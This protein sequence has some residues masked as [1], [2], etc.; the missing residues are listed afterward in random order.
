MPIDPDVELVLTDINRRLDENVVIVAGIRLDTDTARDIANSAVVDITQARL[1]V[2]AYTDMR[3][4]QSQDYYALNFNLM[5]LNVLTDANAYTNSRVTSGINDYI[6]S[7]SE[8]VN[9]TTD[10]LEAIQTNYESMQ[11]WASGVY[12]LQMPS[13]LDDLEALVQSVSDTDTNLLNEINTARTE[14]AEMADRWRNIA[15]TVEYTKNKIIE[16]DFDLY[17]L[18]DEINNRL[19]LELDGRFAVYDSKITAAVGPIGAVVTRVDNLEVAVEDQLAQVQNLEMALIDE[20][21]QLAQQIQSVSVGTNTQFDS[22]RIWHFSE[23]NEGWGGTWY[24]GWL[25]SGNTTQSPTFSAPANQYR[26]VRFR[27]RRVGTP[28]WTGSLSWLGAT[29]ASSVSIPEPTWVTDPN[30]DFGEVTVNVDWSGTLTRLNLTLSND[31]DAIDYFELDWITV[32]RPSPGAGSAELNTE[33]LARI[34]ADTAAGHRIDSLELD[35]T[36]AQGNITT[37]T[38]AISGLGSSITTVNNTIDSINNNIVSLTNQVV[39]IED[40][41]VN[42]GI[43]SSLTNRVT[44]TESDITALNSRADQFDID[45]GDKVS[46]SLFDSLT[47]RVGVTENSISIINSNIVSMGSS[48]TTMDA[49]VNAATLAAQNAHDAVGTKGKVLFQDAA[50]G[51]QDRLI[52]NLWIDTTSGNNT[53]KRWSGSAWVAVTDK[54]A[55]DALLAATNA[56]DALA[57]KADASALNTVETRVTAAEGNISSLGISVST[58]DNSVTLLDTRSSA[59][60]QAA[61][62]AMTTAQGMGKVFFQPAAPPAAERLPHNLWIDTFNNLNRPRRWNSGT[63]TWEIVT[64]KAATDALAAANSAQNAVATKADASTVTAVDQRVTNLNNNLTTVT[65]RTTN[66]ENRINNSTTGLSALAGS[67]NTVNSSVTQINNQ[68]NAQAGTI[69]AL[70]ASVNDSNAS[71]I[72]TASAFVDFASSFASFSMLT[73]AGANSQ[74]L[75]KLSEDY[76]RSPWTNPGMSVVAGY[77]VGPL[78]GMVSSLLRET[79]A[80]SLHTLRQ[81]IQHTSGNRYTV[82]VY[83]KEAGRRYV[84]LNGVNA[85]WG[86]NSH[87]WFD[88]ATGSIR[89]PTGVLNPGILSLADG[90]YRIWVSFEAI[91][92]GNSALYLGTG[93]NWNNDLGQTFTGDPLRGVEVSGYQVEE[94]DSVTAYQRTGLDNVS[95]IE[96]ISVSV[97][98]V[99]SRSALMLRGDDIITEGTLS[100]N[101]IL[102]ESI[103]ADKL[104]INELSS[105][106][107]N[108]GLMRTA[109]SGARME[110][111][112]DKIIVF[113]ASNVIRVRIG[114]LT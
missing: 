23:T 43:I 26:Q 87:C 81:N 5:R 64:D 82:S 88:L 36:A 48:L 35:M 66:I 102:A 70:S 51:P 68:V 92:T 83:V 25:R 94:G 61:E 31:S 112:S 2:M 7:H 67:L 40:N 97:D 54:A 56:V 44:V 63:S 96:A 58:L 59:A 22:F 47:Q 109:T 9:N 11:T 28:T 37:N 16:W 79:S 19:S 1:D 77:G 17:E 20:T 10:L 55:R 39:G 69:S 65:N 105:V 71:V 86:P 93:E 49:Q 33:R 85:N 27:V 46:S 111:H 4:Q 75:I 21:E 108:I 106:T 3:I 14:T 50:P 110:I 103:Q 18:K 84:Y 29:P 74:N 41:L 12:S 38:S 114:N 76:T 72:Q 101:R 95:G 107:S 90:W 15:D 30:G 57:L 45:I 89:A 6:S 73:S 99:S 60:Q 24:D 32:G 91:Q 34:S 8:W 62:D 42:S 113:D 52:H 78:A 100:G 80:L 13:I 104:D 98:G 53:P